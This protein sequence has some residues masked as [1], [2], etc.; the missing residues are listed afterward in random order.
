MAD[1]TLP[2][3]FHALTADVSVQQMD[4]QTTGLDPSEAQRRLQQYGPNRLP[5][6]A[7]RSAFKRF[8]MQFHNLLIYVLIAAAILAAVIG[9]ITDALVIVAVVLVNAIIGFV[10]E[11][12]ANSAMNAIRAMIDPHASVLRGGQRLTI[13]ADEVVPGD[14]VLLEAGDRI[15]ADLRLIKAS[16]LKADEA[17]LTGESVPVDKQVA[18]VA[19]DVPLGD[20]FSMAFSGSFVAAG[21]GE[22]VVI[23]TGAQTQL[24]QISTMIGNVEQLATPLIRQ[25]DHFARQVTMV[26]LG[27]SALVFGFAWWSESYS[28]GDAFMAV[29]GLVVAAI[30]EGLPAMMTITL[31]VGVQRMARRKAIIRRL[32]AV[33]T[34]GAVSVIC[35]DKTG[36]LT[37]NEMT[38]S[39]LVTG[40]GTVSVDGTGYA[41]LGGFASD[42]GALLDPAAETVL[43]AL[44]LAGLLCNDAALR[45]VDDRWI[46]DGD[47]M[48]GALLSVAVK[49]GHND[50]VARAEFTRIA[51]IPFDSRHRYMATLN[52]RS[53]HPPQ[54][55][56]KGAPETIVAMCSDVATAAG[57]QPIDAAHWLAQIDALAGAGQRVIVVAQRLMPAAT[58]VL[59]SD[60]VSGGLTL[61]GLVGLIDPPRPEA[62]AAIAEC[63][64]AGIA[65]KMITGDHAVTARAIAIALGLGDDPRTLTG[66]DLDVLDDAA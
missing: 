45:Q 23:A 48:E 44:T 5:E 32:P 55:F 53:G 20:R 64:A 13:A 8:I 35:S 50:A 39:R 12:R 59:S 21:Q 46:V 30:P 42:D 7:Q 6:G 18:P 33:E 63:H 24:G 25:M 62:I 65:V 29:V 40:D 34:L 28:I 57:P 1:N 41:P 9:H 38:V 10:Q 11:G 3:S 49:A 56:V 52:A 61:L 36:T 19:A 2:T 27:I 43:E 51:E 16:N 4:T 15:A 17:I 22:G 58:S 66:A 31:A 26:I 14:I 54:L 60:D 47:P 37:R